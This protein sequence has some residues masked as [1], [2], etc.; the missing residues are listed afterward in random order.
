[1]VYVFVNILMGSL[2]EYDD[3]LKS[4]DLLLEGKVLVEVK[5][6]LVYIFVILY[7]D[8]SDFYCGYY[9]IF[10]SEGEKNYF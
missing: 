7:G 2:L 1:M 5:E 6:V 3:E 9:E 4:Y 8:W 10:I